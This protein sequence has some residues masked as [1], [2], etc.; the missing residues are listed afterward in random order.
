MKKNRAYRVDIWHTILWSRYKGEVFSSLYALNNPAELDLRFVQ[1]AETE[2]NRVSLSGLDL[3]YHR[4]PYRLLFNGAYD[5]VPLG[6]RLVQFAKEALKTDADLVLLT[7]Y[8]RPEVWVQLLILKLR[9]IKTTIFC[10]STIYDQKQTFLKGLL[11]RL[12][13]TSVDGIFGYGPR[14]RDYVGHYG[15]RADKFH[16][17]CQ[18]A[19]LPAGY[20]P[21]VALAKRIEMAAPQDR[22]QFLYVG[23]LSPEKNLKRLLQAFAIIKKQNEKAQMV[24]VGDGKQRA[25]LEAFAQTLSLN[26]AE[27]FV[28]SKS[29][30]TLFEAYARATC[31]VLP[32]LSEPWGLVVNEALHYGCPVVVSERC[33]CV[34]DLVV[35]GE[36]GFSHKAEDVSDLADKMAKA[37]QAFANT[38]QTAAAC[39]ARIQRYT[40]AISAQQMREGIRKI[41]TLGTNIS[42]P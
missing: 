12:F 32:S 4:Y 9:G 22:P 40:P 39:L 35:D 42:V 7:G 11:K 21:E 41:L 29:G 17:R 37:V 31:F 38:R 19:A 13:F 10:D 3:S 23:R 26:P 5:K 16:I 2:G 20:S 1:V 8:E 6:A 34:L 36:T 30:E 24:F 18:A 15:A 14:S 25:E 33:G 28:G 27:I